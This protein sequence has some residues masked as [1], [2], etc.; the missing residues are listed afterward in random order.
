MEKIA[1][2]FTSQIEGEKNHGI[3][4]KCGKKDY[5][6]ISQREGLKVYGELKMIILSYTMVPWQFQHMSVE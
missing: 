6:K 4:S 5:K 3:G 1:N 2:F